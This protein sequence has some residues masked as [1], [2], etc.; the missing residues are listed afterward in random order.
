MP[1]PGI[2]ASMSMPPLGGGGVGGSSTVGNS[3]NPNDINDVGQ[4]FHQ[5]H[6][7]PWI[8]YQSRHQQQPLRQLDIYRMPITPMKDPDAGEKHHVQQERLRQTNSISSSSREGSPPIMLRHHER[9]KSFDSQHEIAT[10]VL[11]LASSIRDAAQQQ[12]QKPSKGKDGDNDDVERN[13]GSS[14]PLKK[15]KNGTDIIRLKIPQQPDEEHPCH[16]SPL[17]GKSSPE[18]VNGGSVVGV[19]GCDGSHA[20]TP[21][22]SYEV[23]DEHSSKKALEQTPPHQPPQPPH[24]GTMTN[25]ISPG[26][27]TAHHTPGAEE[28]YDFPTS[29]H[30]LLSES[31]FADNVLK[32]LPDGKTWKI[33][34]W[35]ALR[36]QVLP[37]FFPAMTSIDSFLWNVQCWG[38]TEIIDGPDAGAYSHMVRTIF[39]S[40]SNTNWYFLSLG[41]LSP[42]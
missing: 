41:C 29:L 37:K 14:R 18:H 27:N 5:P 2:S 16:V 17:S 11:M 36:R 42:F 1:P 30:A 8:T 22:S 21:N 24:I 19:T 10:S 35:D 7:Q 33:V 20:N 32:W 39:V 31:E 13:Y 15:R 12:Q 6:S 40:Y 3:S 38:F 26:S 4:H 28:G 34:R 23:R 9:S 25:N